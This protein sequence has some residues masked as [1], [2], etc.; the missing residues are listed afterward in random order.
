MMLPP[1]PVAR[2]IWLQ[3]PLTLALLLLTT[4]TD[5]APITAILAWLVG[6][7]ISGFLAWIRERRINA[8]NRYLHAM[9]TGEAV[10]PLPDFG[11][12]G[13]D[14]M[15]MVLLR[16][17]RALRETRKERIARGDQ[18][19]RALEFP[20]EYQQAAMGILSYFS[21]IVTQK[22]PAIPVKIQLEQDG[23]L[24]RMV[25]TTPEGES[26][27]IEHLLNDYTSVVRG[28]KM[29]DEL[30]HDPLALMKLQHKL[31]MTKLELRMTKDILEH[32]SNVDKNRIGQLDA[33]VQQ[34]FKILGRNLDET[35]KQQEIMRRMILDARDL[36]VHM[37]LCVIKEK[38]ARGI[39]PSDEEEIKT[40]ITK[41]NEKSPSLMEELLDMAKNM[42]AGAG[43][44][45]LVDWIRAIVGVLPR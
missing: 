31:E 25:I 33:S 43:G 9:S 40:A 36:T 8:A 15:A 21:E 28:R 45:L 39:S 44:T 3:V 35:S 14:E 10:E 22:Y 32:V 23:L 24:I 17:D 4:T 16:L 29:A 5:V 26:D 13:G 12:L 27:K 11:P 34:L 19:V 41:I 20:P 38:A 30:I 2:T 42:A 37:A 1:R 7:F 18:I 6:L